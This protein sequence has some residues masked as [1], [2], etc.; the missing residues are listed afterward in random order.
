MNELPQSLIC[1]GAVR[2]RGRKPPTP[3]P[4]EEILSILP[5]DVLFALAR[6]HGVEPDLHRDRG[7][8]VAALAALPD[9]DHLTAEADRRNIAYRLGRLRPRQLR[10]L[11]E[12]HRVSLHGLRRK[13]DLVEALT[14]APDSSAILMELE[15]SV[16]AERE[17]GLLLSRDS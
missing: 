4:V 10:E 11:G 5:E 9:S 3:T 16:P 13:S 17:V 6:T 15:A 7:S 14:D 2:G 12:R 8:L 1:L